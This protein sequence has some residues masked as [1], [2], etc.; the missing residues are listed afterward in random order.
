MHEERR[1]RQ[2]LILRH[3]KS[4]WDNPAERDVDRPLN[5]RGEKDAPRMGKWMRHSGLVPDHV[6]ASP[7][8]RAE[9]T[10]KA[11]AKALGIKPKRIHWEPRIYEA[12][13]ARLLEV[14]AEV[15]ED[16]ESVL[17]VGH[18]PGLEELVT[19]LAG[20]DALPEPPASLMKTCTLA[21]L[22]LPADW[23]ELAPGCAELVGVQQP[24]A[25]KEV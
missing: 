8:R 21:T 1:Q 3:A 11:V 10:A 17:L 18:N 2:L 9:Q 14:L 19:Y 7:A 5:R 4:S 6:V 13:V 20:T 23:R 12:S 15:P 25:L 22:T 16:R 24:K